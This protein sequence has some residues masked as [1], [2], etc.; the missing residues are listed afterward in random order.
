MDRI[1]AKSERILRKE[2][3]EGPALIDPYRRT[4]IPLD[5]VADEIWALID[6]ARG[7]G[8]IARRIAE[9]FDAPAVVIERDVAAFLRGLADREIIA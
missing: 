3:A 2:L 4:V 1:Y 5:P 6:G 8:A 9:L 7:E